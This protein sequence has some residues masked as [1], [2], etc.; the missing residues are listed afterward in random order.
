MMKDKRLRSS[1]ADDIMLMGVMGVWAR[2]DGYWGI[3][4]RGILLKSG[5]AT[6]FANRKSNVTCH[7]SSSCSQDLFAL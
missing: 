4:P 2:M 3:I 1:S 6:H 5:N 7:S